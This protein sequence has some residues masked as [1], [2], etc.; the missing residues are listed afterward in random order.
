MT[1]RAAHVRV[2]AGQAGRSIAAVG[3]GQHILGAV[4]RSRVRD[5]LRAIVED[6]AWLAAKASIVALFVLH[7]VGLQEACSAVAKVVNIL[8]PIFQLLADIG[9]LIELLFCFA[10]GARAVLLLL[11][12]ILSNQP[13]GRAAGRTARRG[14]LWQQAATLHVRLGAVR[15]FLVAV[16]AHLDHLR[17]RIPRVMDVHALTTRIM[18]AGSAGHAA[19]AAQIGCSHRGYILLRQKLPRILHAGKEEVLLSARRDRQKLF[20]RCLVH[21]EGVAAAESLRIRQRL[22]PGKLRRASKLRRSLTLWWR[23]RQQL[24]M[25]IGIGQRGLTHHA[26][27]GKRLTIVHLVTGHAGS[28]RFIAER[29]RGSSSRW[30]SDCR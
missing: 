8:W 5:L 20:R 2:V 24:D 25:L 18:F 29:W 22:L 21:S 6:N 30:P 10:K 11:K 26:R 28:L 19:A 17:M 12:T 3:P 14:Y 16:A 15:V 1:P 4:Y 27:L 7:L 9:E 13:A 23:S